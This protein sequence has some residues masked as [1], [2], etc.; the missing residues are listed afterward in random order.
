MIIG[1]LALSF[2]VLNYVSLAASEKNIYQDRDANV[3]IYTRILKTLETLTQLVIWCTL[4][5]MLGEIIG[6]EE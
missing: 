5:I 1:S 3:R 6:L 2:F 4:F